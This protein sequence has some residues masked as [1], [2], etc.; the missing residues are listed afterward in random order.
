MFSFFSS[1]S[2]AAFVLTLLAAVLFGLQLSW[3]GCGA[4]ARPLWTALW[5]SPGQAQTILRTVFDNRT[6]GLVLFC[7]EIALVVHI[8][9]RHLGVANY[10][11]GALMVI[12]CTCLPDLCVPN[13]AL[14]AFVLVTLATDRRLGSLHQ[15]GETRAAYDI[16]LLIGLAGLLYGPASWYILI[17]WIS[18]IWTSVSFGRSAAASLLGLLT[19]AFLMQSLLFVF[20]DIP[21]R[22]IP[23]PIR[24]TGSLP[25]DAWTWP[26]WL[27]ILTAAVLI[28]TALT[29]LVAL[30]RKIFMFQNDVRHTWSMMQWTALLSVL[31]IILLPDH[32]A[33]LYMGCMPFL[34]LLMADFFDS[35]RSPRRAARIFTVLIIGVLL[36]Q[37]ECLMVR[38][39]LP[40]LQNYIPQLIEMI[41]FDSLPWL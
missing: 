9:R 39:G 28:L 19:P 21:W 8:Y 29:A 14:A 15:E 31:L 10:L 2:Y 16:G 36:V 4:D 30:W 11:P 7:I 17:F 22:D 18:M 23:H 25:A 33:A 5:D 32:P 27:S 41:P 1:K 34:S 40:R 24:L 12:G 35:S 20:R 6:V 3:G 37:A 13:T 26:S 38:H